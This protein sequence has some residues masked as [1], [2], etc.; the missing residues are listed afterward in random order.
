MPPLIFQHC[1]QHRRGAEPVE[2]LLYFDWSV[3]ISNKS[4]FLPRALVPPGRVQGCFSNEG[5]DSSDIHRTEREF[6]FR[7]S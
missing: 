2:T 5:K 4:L 7:G 3:H 6:G 1:G